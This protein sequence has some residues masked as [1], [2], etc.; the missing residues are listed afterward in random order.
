[1]KFKLTITLF[2]FI[3][4]SSCQKP[5][6]A[7]ANPTSSHVNQWHWTW[8]SGGI[9]GVRVTP[10]SPL[11]F[12]SLNNDS[13]YTF[14]LDNEIKQQ[15]TYSIT[16]GPNRAILH[17]DKP[18][19]IENLHMKRDQG[20]VTNSSLILELLDENI[21]DGFMHHFDKVGNILDK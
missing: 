1:M 16:V 8:S 19:S 2:A 6:E 14:Q 11:V 21:S 3:I 20:I 12:L 4:I 17:F 15:G 18:V 10:S 13:T 5:L 7:P 9:G